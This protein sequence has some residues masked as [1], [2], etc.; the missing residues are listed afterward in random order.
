MKRYLFDWAMVWRHIVF[1][2]LPFLGI[3]SLYEKF[4]GEWSLGMIILLLAAI[5]PFTAM[6]WLGYQHWKHRYNKP[7]HGPSIHR[8]CTRRLSD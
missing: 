6:G 2:A 4:F 5:L 8:I 1:G 3:V 7:N